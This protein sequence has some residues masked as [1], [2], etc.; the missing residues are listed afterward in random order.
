V[1]DLGLVKF[2]I[3]IS[4]HKKFKILAGYDEP[5]RIDGMSKVYPQYMRSSS[6]SGKYRS[7]EILFPSSI[8]SKLKLTRN[9][10]I[11]FNPKEGH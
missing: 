3:T 7:N 5:A 1:Q 6:T 4:P 2:S 8:N 10:P 11:E 9:W